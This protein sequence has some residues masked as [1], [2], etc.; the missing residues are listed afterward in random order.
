MKAE[1]NIFKVDSSE[2]VSGSTTYTTD[3]IERVIKEY[4]FVFKEVD[5]IDRE[6]V[7]LPS[8]FFEESE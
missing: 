6:A 7:K 4:G 1:G 3:E 2:L 5:E 8:V